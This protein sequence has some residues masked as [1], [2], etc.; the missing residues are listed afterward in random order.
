[1]LQNSPNNPGNMRPQLG[2]RGQNAICITDA[3]FNA[4]PGVN[5]DN[6]EAIRAAALAGNSIWIPDGEFYLDWVEARAGQCWSGTGTLRAT[7]ATADNAKGLI[8]VADVDHVTI[9]GLKLI[10]V[11]RPEGG[12]ETSQDGDRGISISNS[13]NIRVRY[14]DVSGF[15]SFGIVASGCDTIN[16]SS[17][18]VH[19]IGN[20]SCI[21]IDNGSTIFEAAGNKCWNGK[22]YGIEIENGSRHGNIV[23]NECWNCVAGISINY[24][25]KDVY[26]RENKLFDNNNRNTISGSSGI[27]IYMNGTSTKQLENITLSD[28]IVTGNRAYALYVTGGHDGLKFFSNLF[29]KGLVDDTNKLVEIAATNGLH[30]NVEFHGDTFDGSNTSILF[31]ASEISFYKMRDVVFKRPAGNLINLFGVCTDLSFEMPKLLAKDVIAVPNMENL[32]NSLRNWF[33]SREQN[34]QL[35]RIS[36][37]V[38][39]RALMSLRQQKIVGVYWCV[40]ARDLDGTWLLCIDGSIQG[41]GVVGAVEKEVWFYTPLNVV[42][43][44]RAYTLV[45]L[46]NSVATTHGAYFKF[47]LVVV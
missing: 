6:T 44:P 12:R 45:E 29:L 26:V 46:A 34:E 25:V 36:G 10:G 38:M 18:R 14:V 20:Q 24:G 3:P 17:N 9:Q 22:L 35:V 31:T 27:G 40:S 28:N 32:G 4:R 37:G 16:F 21:A 8:N 1:M 41:K 19:D 11:N 30:K 7:N 39:K 43:R 23:L 2:A 42:K 5:H 15:W 13:W 33:F 47:R